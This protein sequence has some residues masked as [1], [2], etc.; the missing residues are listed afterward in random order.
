MPSVN[1]G[2]AMLGLVL[3]ANSVV[4]RPDHSLEEGSTSPASWS[5][6][7]S[8]Q[9]ALTLGASLAMLVLSKDHGPRVQRAI[10]KTIPS[11]R[12]W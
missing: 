11:S 2:P 3:K 1:D 8:T 9:L 4:G 7:E 6:G 10:L 12:P 5:S